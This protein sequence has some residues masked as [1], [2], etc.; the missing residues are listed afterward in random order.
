MRPSSKFTYALRALFDITFHN[1][2]RPTKVDAIAER[3]EIPARFLEQIFQDLKDAKIIGSKRGPNGGYF[4]LKSPEAVTVGDVLRAVEGRIEHPCCFATD[5]EIVEKCAVT[6]RCVTAAVWRDV[7]LRIDG[8]LDSVTL[9]D[10]SLKGD[11]LGLKREAM[12][13]FHYVI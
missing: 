9:A 6:S 12:A 7:T 4:L 8:V 11:A 13:S 1:L 3:E 2:G 10:L 5:A